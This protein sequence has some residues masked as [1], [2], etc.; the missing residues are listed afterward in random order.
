M[1]KFQRD[2]CDYRLRA[3]ELRAIADMR[4]SKETADALLKLAEDY[5]RI[6][7]LADAIERSYHRLSVN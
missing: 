7:E 5:D 1:D 6:A 3:E 2:R 4:C